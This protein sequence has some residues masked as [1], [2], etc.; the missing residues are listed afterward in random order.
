MSMS[1]KDNERI[2]SLIVELTKHAAEKEV[3]VESIQQL[4][5]LAVK[6]YAAKLEGAEINMEARPQPFTVYD[7]IMPIEA[8]RVATEV[9]EA[10]DVELFELGMWQ[11]M[12][13]RRGE[14]IQ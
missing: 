9:L 7:E 3:P 10:V 13:S 1:K 5:T 14:T 11:A 12:W 4:L 8:A 6:L 2:S